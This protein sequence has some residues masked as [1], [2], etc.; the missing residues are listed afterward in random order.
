MATVKAPNKPK[1]VAPRSDKAVPREPELSKTLSQTSRR[2]KVQAAIDGDDEFSVF[3]TSPTSRR[4]DPA[5]LNP[6]LKTE[7]VEGGGKLLRF[8]KGLI[9]G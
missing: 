4:K 2:R 1:S 9:D 6:Q 3:S 8:F 5:E 7:K